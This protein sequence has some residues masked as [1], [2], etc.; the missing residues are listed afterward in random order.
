MLRKSRSFSRAFDQWPLISP[1]DN[2]P[3]AVI[4][5][6]SS[7]HVGMMLSFGPR[8]ISEYSI[9][10][11]EI[12][13]TAFARRIIAAESSDTPMYR[14]WPASTMSAIAPMVS[15]IGTLDQ[16]G[17][18]DKYRRSPCRVGAEFEPGSSSLLQAEH[19][20]QANHRRDRAKRRI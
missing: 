5:I 13:C 7:R 8:E 4:P 14:T 15:S 17:P 11:S 9:C 1:R 6:P 3:Y 18:D 20:N 10:K 19:H 2:T 12:G 16:A